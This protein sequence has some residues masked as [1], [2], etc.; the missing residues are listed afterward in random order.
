[1]DK[2]RT[3]T[4]Y[5][6]MLPAVVLLLVLYAV[7]IITTVIQSFSEVNLLTNTQEFI[8][9]ANYGRTFSNS[10]FFDTLR[11]T[12]LYTVVTVVFKMV[13]GFVYAYFLSTD[14]YLKKPLRFL[15]LL[16]WAIPQV[17]VG[18]LWNW[19][20]DGQY[21]YVNYYLMKLGILSEPISFLA[22]PV[23]AFLSVAF[24]DAW[25]GIPL[26]ALTLISGFEAIPKSLYE[27]A[28]ID[29]ANAL[30][31]FRDVT[32]PGIKNVFISLLTLVTIWTF[33]SFNIIW[34]L[35]QGGPMRATETLMIRIYREAFSNFELGISSTLTIVAVSILTVL[36]L[37][38]MRIGRNADER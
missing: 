12:V 30:Q 33:N 29:G 10:G 14:I 20:L 8:G 11:I 2:R 23:S 1:M 4:P 7:P 3:V 21:G 27:A 36:T 6:M 15:M 25:V 18:T 26:I 22:E 24:V 9:L 19:M 5:L 31:Q 16:P 32:L 28:K 35:T 17:A 34:V 13:F 37:V 38:Y